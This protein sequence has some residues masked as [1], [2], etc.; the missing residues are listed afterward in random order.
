MHVYQPY[1]HNYSIALLCIL[2]PTDVA[3]LGRQPLPAKLVGAAADFT[4]GEFAVSLLGCGESRHSLHRLSAANFFCTSLLHRAV[5]MQ[6]EAAG[7]THF[8]SISAALIT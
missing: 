6:L 5:Q 2:K 8:V 4:S 7:P 1:T 3:F